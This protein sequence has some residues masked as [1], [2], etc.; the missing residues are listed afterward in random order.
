M[1]RPHSHRH[2]FRPRRRC[3][4]LRHNV[5]AGQPCENLGPR[6]QSYLTACDAAVHVWPSSERRISRGEM[7]RTFPRLI[8]M[9]EADYF[10][11]NSSHAR[12]KLMVSPEARWRDLQRYELL[13]RLKSQ[14]DWRVR[15]GD[16]LLPST[17]PALELAEVGQRLAQRVAVAS[18][19]SVLI[20]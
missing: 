17:A 1:Q 11:S 20:R 18:T 7:R 6:A 8:S 19:S 2:G 12:W 14:L 5:D 4:W 15:C 16:H 9:H 13:Q 3:R 10:S